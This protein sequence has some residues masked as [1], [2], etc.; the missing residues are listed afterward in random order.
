MRAKRSL[1]VWSGWLGLVAL[2]AGCSSNSST[3]SS[4]DSGSTAGSVSIQ[5][6]PD[7][8]VHAVCD[9]LGA[10][11]QAAAIPFD[12]ATC[13]LNAGLEIK[14][15]LADATNP[16]IKYDAA[17]AASC[18]A[19][20][21]NLV[22]SCS[23]DQRDASK[24]CEGL[25]FGTL[26]PGAPCST[27]DECAKPSSDQNA[28]CGATGTSDTVCTAFPINH[29]Q[30][31]DPCNATCDTEDDCSGGVAI[32]RT[33]FISDGLECDILTFKCQKLAEIGESCDPNMC[34]LTAFCDEGEGPGVCAALLTSGS[35]ED[36]G[37]A[38]CAPTRYCNAKLQCTPKRADGM[39]C[40]NSDE[41]SGG[42]CPVNIDLMGVC[43]TT[44][45]ASIATCSGDVL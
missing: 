42:S 3:S 27:T 10:C 36:G 1:G 9:N 17:V 35:C 43:G 2:L 38:V 15:R 19:A 22:Q 16:N 25:L 33:C 4:S 40:T 21:A 34:V 32:D 30:L 11:C 13:K 23:P 6:L 44:T 45:L 18:L 14:Q 24:A 41:C 8:F 37:A 26:S 12:L 20:Y 5:D 28:D 29:A 7:Q 31:G 39:P